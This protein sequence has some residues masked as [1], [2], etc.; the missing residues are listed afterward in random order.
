M[1]PLTAAALG[2]TVLDIGANLFAGES[3]RRKAARA[4][5]DLLAG[6]N[7]SRDI[8]GDTFN[9]TSSMYDPYVARG[10]ESWSNMQGIERDLDPNKYAMPEFGTYEYGGNVNDFLDPSMAYE[11]EQGQRALL[12]AGAGTGGLMSGKT[13]KA[14]QSH[15]QGLAQGNW[16]QAQA[17]ME[18]DRQFNY[19]DYLNKFNADRDSI[20]DRY[21]KFKD[22]YGR[23]N[24]IYGTGQTAV[25][26]QAG[27]RNTYGTQLAGL[28]G[29][30]A[31]VRAQGQYTNSFMDDLV[32]QAGNFGKGVGQAF[33]A[34]GS[35][36]PSVGAPQFGTAQTASNMDY[37]AA[38]QQSN[39]YNLS[40]PASTR[41]W[42]L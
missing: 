37:M 36:S 35:A 11:M 41:N 29:Q 30:E 18:R 13:L 16:N 28:A 19:S 31:N 26:N 40:A 1:D 3:N 33:G 24:E 20:N 12:G 2:G 14:L 23:A 7:K 8:Y 5:R 9:E 32:G 17:A 34:F 38:Q 42:N 39:P 27:L 10:E 22:Q 21:T 15:S 25:G 4:K 6:I